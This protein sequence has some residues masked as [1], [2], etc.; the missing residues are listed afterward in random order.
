MNEAARWLVALALP[1]AVIAP[2]LAEETARQAAPAALEAA[3]SLAYFELAA[4]TRQGINLDRQHALSEVSLHGGL[5][6]KL[7]DGWR[8]RARERAVMETRLEPSTFRRL[9][10]DESSV[11]Y[12]GSGCSV[13]LGA[14][15]VVWDRRIA[16]ACWTWC[17][18]RAGSWPEVDAT[19]TQWR[20]RALTV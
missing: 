10:I 3:A 2:A 6:W 17:M 14:Q 15:Q 13:R 12:A 5:R 18:G 7:A 19:G 8:V 20:R 9:E 4:D 16:C 1:L 11:E